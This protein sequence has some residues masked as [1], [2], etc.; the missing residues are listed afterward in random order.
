MLELKQN[1]LEKKSQNS[2]HE[3][4]AKF[5]GKCFSCGKFGHR[6]REC[7]NKKTQSVQR[8]PGR[9]DKSV[10]FIADRAERK[11]KIRYISN[12]IKGPVTIWLIKNGCLLNWKT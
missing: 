7:R 9:S 3:K 12:L 1:S 2:E 5:H 4:S 8:A 6:S 11:I 10:C